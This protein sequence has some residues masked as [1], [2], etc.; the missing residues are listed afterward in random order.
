MMSDLVINGNPP[1]GRLPRRG[2]CVKTYID[3]CAS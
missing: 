2:F 3:L 1:T